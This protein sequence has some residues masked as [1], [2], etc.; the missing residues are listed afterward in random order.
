MSIN[1]IPAN[2][3][4]ICRKCGYIGDVSFLKHNFTKLNSFGKN[5]SGKLSGLASVRT[6]NLTSELFCPPNNWVDKSDCYF[7]QKLGDSLLFETDAI[8]VA[9]VLL[10]HSWSG[11]ARIKVDD[12]AIAEIDLYS[13]IGS[14]KTS[15]PIFLGD[16]RHRIEI[17]NT[18]R[19]NDDSIASQ[20]WIFGV[21][22]LVVK[23]N[24]IPEIAYERRNNGN[25]YPLEFNRLLSALP[26]SAV[27]LDCGA[28][29]RCHD[30]PRVINFEYTQF[31]SPDVF[32]D[33][34]H[35]PFRSNSFD[36]VL[37]QAVIEHLYDPFQ[38]AREI[39]RVLKPGGS[40]YCEAAFMQ[41]LHA[42]PYHYF[43][44]T[45][46]GVEELFKELKH[47]KTEC[48]GNISD[49]LSWMYRLTQLLEKGHGEKIKQILSLTNELD[50]HI[51]S[52]ELRQF[53]S[54]VIYLGKKSV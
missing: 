13:P 35:L 30:D 48:K 28:G 3:T 23:E 50:R 31:S 19:K 49:T 52:D 39:V 1:G 14:V 4:I 54:F 40:V 12:A 7:S 8:S 25:P 41:P 6:L 36:L 15:Y 18:G 45:T 32:G 53:A 51:T 42:V 47:I 21:K 20:I 46:W 10:T 37:S 9:L 26:A 34:H 5:K 29:D 11:I 16:G 38:A 17:E 44:T 22:E 33:G 24:E 43:N 27:A 2:G